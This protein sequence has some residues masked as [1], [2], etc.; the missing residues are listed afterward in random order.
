MLYNYPETD[1]GNT[2][3]LP[4]QVMSQGPD[5]NLYSTI[6]TDGT[7][8]AD[9][10]Y[11]GTAYKMTTA[12]KPTTIYN[13]CL[14][15]SCSDGE[16]PW[17]GLTLG[18]DGNFYGTTG[19]GEYSPGTVFRLTPDGKTLTTLYSFAQTAGTPTDG[20]GG[21]LYTVFEGQDGFFY[22][23]APQVYTGFY[24]VLYR[25]SP[26]GQVFPLLDF[27]Y[28]N[29]SNPNLPTQG[30]DGNIYGTT[31]AGGS[32]NL[33]V[34]YSVDPAGNV[35][36]LHDFTGYPS[37]GSFPKGVLVQAKDGN[38]YGVTYQG[39]TANLGTIFSISASGDYYEVVHSFTGVPSDGTEPLAGL[40]LGSDGNLYGTTIYGGTNNYGAIF[41]FIPSS[42]NPPTILYN[43]CS[44]AGCVDGILPETPLVQHTNGIFY[45]NTS[46][47]SL[48]GSVFYS[49][50]MGLSPFTQLVTPSGGVGRTVGFQGQGF[51]GTREVSFNG[52]PAEFRVVSDTYLTAT[53]PAGATTGP[54]SILT[55]KGTMNSSREFLV[56]PTVNH[57]SPTSGGTAQ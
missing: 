19:G 33:G 36:V 52:T 16:Y 4:P 42:G 23:V 44:K 46:G 43:L 24:G 22:G 8:A 26:S 30:T 40:T 6:A 51:T 45:G 28:T 47:N 48:G 21:P 53:V 5:G 31:Q 7:H 57:L 3:V 55:P 32:M 20:D 41:Q 1:R 2:G 18:T 38:F 29:G 49:L 14:R 9:E 25:M 12:G 27:N 17:G 15:P 56:T 37:D 11:A 39:G 13:F 34:V 35:N 10:G 54:V 50:D